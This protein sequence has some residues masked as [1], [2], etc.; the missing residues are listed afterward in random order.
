[1]EAGFI[2]THRGIFYQVLALICYPLKTKLIRDNFSLVGSCNMRLLINCFFTES[3]QVK[4]VKEA[5]LAQ[6]LDID[7][8]VAKKL[9][10]RL[11]SERYVQCS[12]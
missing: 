7:I 1:M 8:E 6:R 10:T 3:C 2:H 11:I 5:E 4:R 12:S 9:I